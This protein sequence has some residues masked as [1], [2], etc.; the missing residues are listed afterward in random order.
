[1]SSLDIAPVPEGCSRPPLSLPQATAPVSGVFPAGVALHLLEIR[2]QAIKLSPYHAGLPTHR[3]IRLGT[4]IGFDG[5][6]CSPLLFR[7]QVSH[8]TQRYH[9]QSL[10]AGRGIQQSASWRRRGFHVP[11]EQATTGEG[12]PSTPS[13]TVLY[14]PRMVRRPAVCRFTA[15]SP[16]TPL[17]HP[18]GGAS[19]NE[20]SSRVHWYSP[21]RSSPHL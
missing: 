3:P 7:S 12:A 19:R 5:M 9:L 6:L 16:W 4:T 17:H 13:T 15:A 21:V 2:I 20:A 1:M 10:P 8:Q 11:H 18:I 14:R